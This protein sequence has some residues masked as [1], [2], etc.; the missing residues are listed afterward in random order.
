[1]PQVDASLLDI[2]QAAKLLNVSVVSLRRWTDSGRLACLRIGG[3]RERR[4]RREDLLAFAEEQGQSA[5]TSAR[6]ASRGGLARAMFEG[7]AI[8]YGSHL[9]AVYESNRG[10]G[11]MAVPFLIDGLASGDTC[12]LVA[13]PPVRR[14]LLG[15]LAE[16]RPG[17]RR[18]VQTGQFVVSPNMS[19]GE[20][21]FSYFDSQFSTVTRLGNRGIRVL[22]DMVWFLEQELSIDQL[23]NFE[24]RYGRLLG[25]S[26]PVI[27]LCLYDAR[28]F[29]GIGIARAL[30]THEDTFKHPLSRFL[31][32]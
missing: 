31:V 19:G 18:Y 26:Y 25:H 22:G 7:I 15:Q 32:S 11:R 8:D 6:D 29:S 24:M 9:C 30:K 27:S 14:D 16:L 21:M 1:M 20:E 2:N 12:Y 3:K 4:F 23:T 5:A 13:S 10:R 17:F 28:R